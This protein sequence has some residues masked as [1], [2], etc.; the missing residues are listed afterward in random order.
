M[1]GY[2]HDTVACL[3]VTLCIVT[4]R[5]GVG[6]E[7]SIVVF[8]GDFLYSLHQALLLY[9]ASFSHNTQRKTEPSKL[10]HLE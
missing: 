1:I 4:L 9:D 6:V 3:S 5:V 2:C 8:V 10:P 7:S